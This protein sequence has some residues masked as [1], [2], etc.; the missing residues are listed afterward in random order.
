[1][2]ALNEMLMSPTMNKNNFIFQYEFVT[3][4]G[5]K[6]QV[7]DLKKHFFFVSGVRSYTFCKLDRFK[8]YKTFFHSLKMVSLTKWVS[9]FSPKTSNI[10][11]SY[12]YLDK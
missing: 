7:S 2:L 6:I 9:K 10:I 12:Q 5:N 3:A 4:E 8:T 1:M 11:F